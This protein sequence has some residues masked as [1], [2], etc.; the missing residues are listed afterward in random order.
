MTNLL[1]KVPD[2]VRDTLDQSG[3]WIC[4][5]LFASAFAIGLSFYVENRTAHLAAQNAK[6]LAIRQAAADSAVA[7]CVA[8][9][10]TLDRISKHVRGVNDL[11]ETLIANSEAAIHAAPPGDPLAAARRGNLRRLRAARREIGAVRS[12]PTPTVAQ[13]RA[14]ADS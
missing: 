10:P 13:C 5:A 1:N 6:T 7:Q 14:R 11:V 12:F 2:R 4:V 8:S 9:I 3:F